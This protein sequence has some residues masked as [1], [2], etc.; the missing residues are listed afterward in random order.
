MLN[1]CIATVFSKIKLN[2]NNKDMATN[3]KSVMSFGLEMVGFGAKRESVRDNLSMQRFRSHFGISPGVIVAIIA[4]T[5]NDIALKHL[6]M[7][8]WWRKLY[9]TE[10]V[11]SGR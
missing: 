9:E 11:M 6:L 10:H 5:K 7:T 8:L 1:L 3:V 4:D 2:C